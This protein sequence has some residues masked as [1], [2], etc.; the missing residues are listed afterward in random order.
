MAQ[1]QVTKLISPVVSASA[2]TV[3]PVVDSDNAADMQ[4]GLQG[5]LPNM[6]MLNDLVGSRF[7]IANTFSS[8]SSAVNSLPVTPVQKESTSCVINS[9]PSGAP[10]S[11][12]VSGSPSAISHAVP[13]SCFKEVLPCDISP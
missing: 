11:T 9:L 1:P 2:S 4:A 13:E 7:R 8:T 3:Q 12:N 10:A 6:Q 5:E